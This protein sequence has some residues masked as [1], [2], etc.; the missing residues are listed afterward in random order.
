LDSG[1]ALKRAVAMSRG[2]GVIQAVHFSELGELELRAA[3]DTPDDAE[4]TLEG[5]SFP[6]RVAQ[7]ADEIWRGRSFAPGARSYEERAF[8][9]A[10]LL[11]LAVRQPISAWPKELSQQWHRLFGERWAKTEDE[12]AV[13]ELARELGLDP[14]DER[15]RERVKGAVHSAGRVPR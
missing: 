12:R 14:R 13:R 10:A 9:R 6:T 4:S 1:N 8:E 7:R 15:A 2:T 3:S 11:C 5:L